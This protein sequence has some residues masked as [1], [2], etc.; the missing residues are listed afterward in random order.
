MGAR[1]DRRDLTGRRFGMLVVIAQA[2]SYIRPG[3]QPLRKSLCK[4]ADPVSLF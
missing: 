2:P 1:K 4:I 3:G